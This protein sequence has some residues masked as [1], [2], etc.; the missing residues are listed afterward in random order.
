[1]GCS[2]HVFMVEKKM[3]KR[4]METYLNPPIEV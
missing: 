3:E 1:M 4:D 2:I